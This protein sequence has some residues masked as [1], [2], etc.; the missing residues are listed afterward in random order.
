MI[1]TTRFEP[2]VKE[3]AGLARNTAALAIS[4]GVAMR[5]VGLRL[6]IVSK[7]AGAPVVGLGPEHARDHRAMAEVRGWGAVAPFY[8]EQE[9]PLGLAHAVLVSEHEERVTVDGR[10]SELLRANIA[11]QRA[12]GDAG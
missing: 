4:C 5:P 8:I 10:E 1:S 7:K 9:A 3:E 12:P 6:I 2:V 11:A